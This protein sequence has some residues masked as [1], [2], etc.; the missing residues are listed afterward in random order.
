M[1]IPTRDDFADELRG[2]AL[3]G[4]VLV[5]APFLG[6][7][8]IGYTDAS[9]ATFADRVAAFVVVAAAQAKFYLLF[10]FL[11]GYSLS[12]IVKDGDANSVARFRRRLWGLAALGLVHAW[13]FFIGDILLIY[14][15]I[16]ISLLWTRHKS[17]DV[18]MSYAKW[19]LFIWAMVLLALVLV[20]S[21][22][23][24]DDS[25]Q[26]AARAL[27]DVALANGSFV[28]ATV[29]RVTVWPYAL[30]LITVLN[31][32]AVFAMFCVGLVAGRKK[33]LA[34][35]SAHSALWQRGS[36]L[37]IWIGV[38][39]AM[40]SAW[41]SVGP[42]ANIIAPGARELLGVVL[43]FIA[44]PLLSWGY[45]AWMA[46][47]RIKWPQMFAVF[48]PAGRMSLTGY[49]GESVLLS[50]IFCGYG[51]QRYGKLGAFEVMLLA[52]AVWL[53]LDLFAHCW[54]RYFRYGP[55]EW[56]LRKWVTMLRRPYV[57]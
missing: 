43:G 46:T 6:V 47:L 3:L 54:Q 21:A 45:V 29:A 10:S 7:S 5:N 23:P 53:V 9:L 51:L 18:V 19:A 15:V 17:D 13:F 31:G 30:A 11:F 1:S 36:R 2:F 38:P 48:R 25:G 22:F 14:A 39:A 16:G 35:P 33:V 26:D 20:A 8:W 28:E 12:Y 37:A 50:L 41:L 34:T 4:I 52:L 57:T 56:L 42:S 24:H 44:A 55:L 32:A 49:I 27:A 40:T